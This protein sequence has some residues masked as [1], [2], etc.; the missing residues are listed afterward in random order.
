MVGLAV[1]EQ[2]GRM[3]A[4]GIRRERPVADGFGQQARLDNS[5]LSERE[6][7]GKNGSASELLR[8]LKVKDGTNYKFFICLQ[9][10]MTYYVGVRSSHDVFGMLG[11][12]LNIV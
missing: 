12:P 8:D 7:K 9:R 5:S 6:R 10:D 1:K 4:R 2:V 3:L 11:G